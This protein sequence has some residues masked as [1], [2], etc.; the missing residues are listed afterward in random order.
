MDDCEKTR[1]DLTEAMRNFFW[2]NDDYSR[3]NFVEIF[4]DY[5]ESVAYDIGEEIYDEENDTFRTMKKEIEGKNKN[6]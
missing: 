6:E 5:A 2:E 1:S 4:L 3:E